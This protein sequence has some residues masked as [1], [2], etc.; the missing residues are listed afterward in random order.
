[1]RR[2]KPKIKNPTW[3]KICKQCGE[4]MHGSLV[5]GDGICFQY[6]NENFGDPA[7][8]NSEAIR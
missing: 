8:Y 7:D 1:M 4:E 5:G 3:F 6:T 2:P